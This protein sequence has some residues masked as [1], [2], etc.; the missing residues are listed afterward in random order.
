MKDFK[1]L[2]PLLTRSNQGLMKCVRNCYYGNL[3][4]H[5]KSVIQVGVWGRGWGEEGDFGYILNEDLIIAVL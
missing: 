3:N 2:C 5:W 1:F 4:C